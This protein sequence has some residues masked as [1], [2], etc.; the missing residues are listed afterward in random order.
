[1]IANQAGLIPDFSRKEI[2]RIRS[3]DLL[4]IQTPLWWWSYPSLL[5][6]Y[7]EN[8][9]VYDDLFSLNN[10]ETR[11]N[12]ESQHTKSLINKQV[13]LSFTTGG[14][15]KFMKNYFKSSEVLCKPMQVQFEFIGY[16]FLKPHFTW[17]VGEKTVL[18]KKG[19]QNITSMLRDFRDRLNSICNGK[20]K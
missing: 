10:V 11:N 8:V 12:S 3:A 2:E 13:F 9:F 17:A 20:I 15:E 14:S 19:D 5:K 1:L 18:N 6:A 4:Y 7:I 16:H